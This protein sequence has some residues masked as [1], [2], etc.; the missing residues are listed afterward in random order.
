MDS[1]KFSVRE[2]KYAIP[3]SP[4]GEF[5]KYLTTSNVI[6]SCEKQIDVPLNGDLQYTRVGCTIVPLKASCY[7]RGSALLVDPK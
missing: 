2:L 3:R 1:P 4:M 7:Y 6:C 5:R